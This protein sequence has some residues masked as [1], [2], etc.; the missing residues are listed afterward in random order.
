MLRRRRIVRGEKKHIELAPA[1][2]GLLR[3]G[4]RLMWP[5]ACQEALEETEEEEEERQV[6][7]LAASIALLQRL[8]RR[9]P[10]PPP[11]SSSRATAH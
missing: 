3:G 7:P 1:F 2:H 10:P 5:F 6:L 8:R 9:R 11:P 4:V